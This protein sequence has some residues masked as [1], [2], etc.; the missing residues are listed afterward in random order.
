RLWVGWEEDRPVSAAATFVAA[1]INDVTLVATVP[2]A[3]GR[4]YGAALA[5]RASLANPAL[6]ALLIASTEGRRV[7]ERM[8]YMSLFR[9]TLWSRDRPGNMN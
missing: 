7:Y 1:E 3:R 8:G 2:E 6:P 9:F 5:W 4:G